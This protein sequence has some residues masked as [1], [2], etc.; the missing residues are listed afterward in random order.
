MTERQCDNCLRRFPA[1][2][3]LHCDACGKCYC[4]RCASKLGLCECAGD[5]TYFD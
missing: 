4:E 1:D 2:E 3:V 5:L